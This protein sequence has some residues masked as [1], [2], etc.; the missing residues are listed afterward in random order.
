MGEGDGSAPLQRDQQ[1]TVSLIQATTHKES[2]GAGHSRQAAAIA[3]DRA[4]AIGAASR[5]EW[6]GT[7][8]STAH[9][10]V[11]WIRS[12]RQRTG[13][14]ESTRTDRRPQ[15][16]PPSPLLLCSSPPC[17]WSSERWVRSWEGGGDGQQMR[18]VQAATALQCLPLSPA[19]PSLRAVR[20]WALLRLLL[21]P[22]KRCP[23]PV[24]LVDAALPPPVRVA[25]SL[26]LLQQ[27][28]LRCSSAA[29]PSRPFSASLHRSS[30]AAS[31]RY[32]RARK[33][34]LRR[35]SSPSHPATLF[36][37]L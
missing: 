6:L 5:A 23:A 34:E 29:P 10:S 7:Q 25:A 27:P 22:V 18:G 31:S 14:A 20:A 26:T 21:L 30:T 15:L 17:R 28:P 3:D 35:R 33:A 24:C 9:G 16:P 37:L 19:L 1:A 13:A 32:E 8:P 4:W 11:E 12:A 2:E 36:I